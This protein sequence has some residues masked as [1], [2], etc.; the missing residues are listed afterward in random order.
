[1]N[2][3]WLLLL[4]VCAGCS[5]KAQAPAPGD[6]VGSPPASSA[7]D[8]EIKPGDRAADNE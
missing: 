7:A 5:K 1:M 3:F 2:K 6:N 8:D 4:L